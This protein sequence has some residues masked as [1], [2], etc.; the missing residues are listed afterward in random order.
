M[1][2]KL[3]GIEVCFD[4]GLGCAVRCKQFQCAEAE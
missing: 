2:I 3:L 1:Y 4:L